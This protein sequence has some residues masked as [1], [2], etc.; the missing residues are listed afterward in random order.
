MNT[1]QTRFTRPAGTLP[2]VSAPP[3]HALIQRGDGHASTRNVLP[4]GRSG[5]GFPHEESR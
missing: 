2:R 5:N 4:S 1:T 3:A